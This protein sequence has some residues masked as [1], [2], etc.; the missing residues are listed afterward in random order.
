M[1]GRDTDPEESASS[2]PQ[3]TYALDAPSDVDETDD[4]DIVVAAESL[5]LVFRGETDVV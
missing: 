4:G 1:Q 2:P 3:S 5:R